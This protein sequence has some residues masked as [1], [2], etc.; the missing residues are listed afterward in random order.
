[1]AEKTL[2]YLSSSQFLHLASEL[3]GIFVSVCGGGNGSNGVEFLTGI[4]DDETMIGVIG[5]GME[6]VGK[7]DLKDLEEIQYSVIA[8]LEEMAPFVGSA[9]TKNIELA[10]RSPSTSTPQ[11]VASYSSSEEEDDLFSFPPA[12]APSPARTLTIY[13]NVF[14]KSFVLSPLFKTGQIRPDF[15]LAYQTENEKEFIAACTSQLNPEVLGR[16]KYE[17][18]NKLL[19]TNQKN[20]T[21]LRSLTSKLMSSVPLPSKISLFQ[22]VLAYANSERS[23]GI[24]DNSTE[25]N[26]FYQPDSNAIKVETLYGVFE[27]ALEASLADGSDY[28]PDEVSSLEVASSPSLFVLA[29]QLSKAVQVEGRRNER[30]GRE[31]HR[32]R[33]RYPRERQFDIA[34]HREAWHRSGASLFQLPRTVQSHVQFS[35]NLLKFALTKTSNPVEFNDLSK[36]RVFQTVNFAWKNGYMIEKS[37]GNVELANRTTESICD[38]LASDLLKSTNTQAILI[39]AFYSI[40]ASGNVETIQKMERVDLLGGDYEDGKNIELDGTGLNDNKKKWGGAK[41]NT[42]S[43]YFGT[44]RGLAGAILDADSACLQK[45][46]RTLIRMFTSVQSVED[47]D[48]DNDAFEKLHVRKQIS[49]MLLAV[50]HHPSNKAAQ[51]EMR[52]SA[53]LHVFLDSLSGNVLTC[54]QFLRDNGLEGALNCLRENGGNLHDPQLHSSMSPLRSNIATVKEAL[55]LLT[56]IVEDPAVNKYIL[57]KATFKLRQKVMR[58]SVVVLE[59]LFPEFQGKQFWPLLRLSGTQNYFKTLFIRLLNVTAGRSL[60]MLHLG[61]L[62]CY[63][64]LDINFFPYDDNPTGDKAVEAFKGTKS[65]DELKEATEAIAREEEEKVVE[66]EKLWKDARIRAAVAGATLGAVDD[67]SYPSLL[68]E[69]EEFKKRYADLNLGGIE[70]VDELPGFLFSDKAERAGARTTSSKTLFKEWKKLKR[71]LL[72]D[73][74]PANL[75]SVKYMEADI[76][77]ARAVITCSEST[78]YAFGALVFDIWLPPDFPTVPP[79]IEIL[80]TGNGTTMM[81]PNL[82]ADGKVCMALLN[83]MESEHTDERWVPGVSNLGQVL[84]G[85]QAQLLVDNPGTMKGL[86]EGTEENNRYNREKRIDTLRWAIADAI[87]HPQLGFEDVVKA[88]FKASANAIRAKVLTWAADD[89][90]RK[91]KREAGEVLR[92]LDK[93]EKE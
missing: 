1:M 26:K 48:V 11:V 47:Q 36:S 90:G 29:F 80:T 82:Y 18:L 17:D 61:A 22:T 62:S 58:A 21:L 87:K 51:I 3:W 35:D 93:I 73:M 69:D 40:F 10:A 6:E 41:G 60:D 89:S 38:I 64:D 86:R 16:K 12:P 55:L 32:R 4:I 37:K 54:W 65:F 63:E 34:V 14:E 44:A 5:I 53:D 79:M 15:R 78:P 25:A 71:F 30:I 42:N 68:L 77:R 72:Q 91:F 85:I 19:I 83:N 92:L 76:S 45:F 70:M 33:G 46:A 27:C 84:L 23:L 28:S 52:N 8:V 57:E 49:R 59:R 50:I 24:E 66:S 9:I 39:D 88:H 56:H 31:M 7:K 67:T 75:I 20:Q 81:S 43:I 2:S 13:G 74:G